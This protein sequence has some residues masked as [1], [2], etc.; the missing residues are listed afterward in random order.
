MDLTGF[1]IP[2][3]GFNGLLDSRVWVLQ[4]WGFQSLAF[5]GFGIPKF[6]FNGFGDF[7]VWI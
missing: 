5:T 7:K 1:W 2:I 6:G 4:V 3:S